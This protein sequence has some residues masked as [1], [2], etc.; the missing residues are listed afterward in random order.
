[1]QFFYAYGPI[2][3][4][5]DHMDNE[6]KIYFHKELIVTFPFTELVTYFAVKECDIYILM[7]TCVIWLRAS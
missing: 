6:A 2:L 5:L 7:I 4:T 1:M 3:Y